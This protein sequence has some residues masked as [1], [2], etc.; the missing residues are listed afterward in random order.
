MAR[1]AAAEAETR[2]AGNAAVSELR[3][4]VARALATLLHTVTCH[5]ATA[6]ALVAPYSR[7]LEV[8]VEVPVEVLNTPLIGGFWQ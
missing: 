2:G 3:A 7:C 8:V 5:V 1:A 4:Q 6:A